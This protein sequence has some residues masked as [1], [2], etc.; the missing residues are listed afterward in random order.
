VV[1]VPD[2]LT[3]GQ[4]LEPVALQHSFTTYPVGELSQRTLSVL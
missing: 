2:W 1:T 4:F 3:I